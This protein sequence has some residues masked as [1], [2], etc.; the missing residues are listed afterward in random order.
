MTPLLLLVAAVLEVG[1]DAAVRRGLLETRTGWLL[2]GAASLVGYGFAVNWSRSIDFGRLMGVY[3]VVFF[4][5]SQAIAALLFGEA[6][7]RS[8]L[9]GG[10]L[11][12]AG[13]AV[14]QLGTGR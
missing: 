4:V 3:I 7:S 1:G 2:L 5:V 8:V 6:P 11:I 10:A 12:V 14:I 13:G 9:V